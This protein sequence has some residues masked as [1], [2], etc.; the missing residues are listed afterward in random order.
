M[1]GYD[2]VL[3]WGGGGGNGGERERRRLLNRICA[4][5]GFYFHKKIKKFSLYS[6]HIACL[7]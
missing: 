6:K 4:V 7:Q 3:M 5:A 1:L 2:V